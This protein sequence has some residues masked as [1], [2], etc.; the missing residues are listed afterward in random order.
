MSAS[1]WGVLS[2]W[3]HVQNDNSSL[4]ACNINLI[5]KSNLS[6]FL[7]SFFLSFF[8]S[9]VLLLKLEVSEWMSDCLSPQI[10]VKSKLLSSQKRKSF[11]YTPCINIYIHSNQNHSVMYIEFTPFYTN[12]Y[13]TLYIFCCNISHLAILYSQTTVF[14][15]WK[16]CH[17]LASVKPLFLSV[18]SALSFSEDEWISYINLTNVWETDLMR[19]LPSLHFPTRHQY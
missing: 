6:F 15:W 14:N 12:T 1:Y 19:N 2:C 9:F 17:T 13:S 11:C 8:R 4:I 16:Y 18:V 3:R 10:L 5:I 7:F